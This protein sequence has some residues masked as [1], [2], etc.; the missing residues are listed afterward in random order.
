[1]THTTRDFR[2][3]AHELIDKLPNDATWPD[4]IDR[5]AERQDIFE[6]AESSGYDDST[7][8]PDLQEY[9]QLLVERGLEGGEDTFPY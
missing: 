4:L 5:A 1:M 2:Q 7:E 9:D 8:M 3:L 6:A